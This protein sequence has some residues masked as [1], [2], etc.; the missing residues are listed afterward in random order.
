MQDI[1]ITPEGVYAL[2]SKL[3]PHKASGPDNIPA[4]VLKELEQ[5]TR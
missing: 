2:L 4:R 3:D 5:P 1:T